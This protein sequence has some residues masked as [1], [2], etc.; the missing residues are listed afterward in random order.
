[1]RLQTERC[2]FIPNASST[3]DRGCLH[4]ILGLVLQN[5]S[6]F[7]LLP[8]KFLCLW[9]TCNIR[10]FE[11]SIKH[12]YIK[13][14][15]PLF[16]SREL[17]LFLL[18]IVNCLAVS[19]FTKTLLF[20]FRIFSINLSLYALYGP[21]LNSL[22]LFL[23]FILF[24]WYHLR[25]EVFFAYP[26]FFFLLLLLNNLKFTSKSWFFLFKLFNLTYPLQK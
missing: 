7:A 4:L 13:F 16:S 11:I 10:K 1:M 17:M 15:F 24:F 26:F 20:P 8:T 6:F 9:G 14:D 22:W 25:F 5:F 18:T 3:D 19:R 2:I 21:F 12:Y 23:R